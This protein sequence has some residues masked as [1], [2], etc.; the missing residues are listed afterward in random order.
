MEKSD[1]MALPERIARTLEALRSLAPQ[2]MGFCHC[3]GAN[4]VHRIWS[5]F[6]DANMEVHVDKRLSLPD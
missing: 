5:E 3:T 2:R 4:A 6:P 1:E